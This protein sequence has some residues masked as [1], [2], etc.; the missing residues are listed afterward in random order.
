MDAAQTALD[1]TVAALEAKPSEPEKP[2]VTTGTYVLMNIPYD[3]FYAADVNNSVKGRC[4][5]I[6]N[7]NKVRTA[8]LAGG[9]YHVD[10]SGDEITGV[11]F[12]VKVGEGV[13]LS[14]Y[15]KI[16]ERI[17]CRHYG[18]KQRSD[19]YSHIHRKRCSV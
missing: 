12:P 7:E 5:Y 15:K 1:A 2:D 9:S 11:T 10:A 16:T 8:G 14:K 13:D 18:Y 17:F 19:K 4:I 3:Q 6:S